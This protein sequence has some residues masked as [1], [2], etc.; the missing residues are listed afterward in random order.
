MQVIPYWYIMLLDKD[1]GIPENA[2]TPTF[3]HVTK[4]NYEASEESTNSVG[5]MSLF[6]LNQDCDVKDKQNI[7]YNLT[8]Y[9]VQKQTR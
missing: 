8:V 6:P 4:I 9:M 2:I 3:Q 5:I 1:I 7:H